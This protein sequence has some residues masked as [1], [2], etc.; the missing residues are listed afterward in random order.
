MMDSVKHEK[1]FDGF[2][3]L[4]ANMLCNIIRDADGGCLD[5]R[6]Y[7]MRDKRF[8]MILDHFDIDPQAAREAFIKRWQ[9][10]P[11]PPATSAH[12]LH[13]IQSDGALSAKQAAGQI[14][15]T[16]G[17][18]SQLVNHGL[19]PHTKIGRFVRI[20]KKD[21]A[22]IKRTLKLSIRPYKAT[23]RKLKTNPTYAIDYTSS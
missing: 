3:T 1:Q 12:I 18:M 23:R 10:A 2:E 5:S 7:L 15:I 17:R 4:N 6:S 16:E 8:E 13:T 21:I 14:G 20:N 19:I 9:N 11:R 22:K